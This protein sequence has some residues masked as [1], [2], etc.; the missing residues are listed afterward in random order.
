MVN[1][2]SFN[3]GSTN[4]S[5]RI[6]AGSQQEFNNK[7]KNLGVPDEVI[8]QGPQAV[9]QYCQ[10]NNITLPQPPQKPNEQESSVFGG[11]MPEFRGAE[12]EPPAELKQKLISLG[13]PEDIISQGREAVMQYCQENNITLPEPPQ[14]EGSKLDLQA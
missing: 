4:S 1:G 14:K 8:A 13:V 11:K 10:E 3:N 6:G 7:L 5:S 9:M 2:V 12:K